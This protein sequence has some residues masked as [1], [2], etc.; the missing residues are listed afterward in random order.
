MAL[1]AFAVNPARAVTAKSKRNS[2]SQ[3]L[4]RGWVCRS[5]PCCPVPIRVANSCAPHRVSTLSV[6]A[7]FLRAEHDVLLVLPNQSAS[8]LRIIP[9]RYAHVCMVEEC[10]IGWFERT[11]NRT[12]R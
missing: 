3:S 4:L 12:F 7:T 2:T 8:A 10:K 1:S 5:L 11:S 9:G 6:R